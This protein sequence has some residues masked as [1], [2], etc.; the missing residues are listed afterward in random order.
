MNAEF[1]ALM[2][3]M[4]IKHYTTEDPVVKSSI[5]ER[6]IRTI[7]D[8]MFRYFTHTGKWVWYN[9]L[10]KLEKS[11]NNSYHRSIKMRPIDVNRR[12]TTEV[13]KNLYGEE[14]KQAKNFKLPIGTKVRITRAENPFTKG[15]SR[16]F[17]DE[18]FTITKHIPGTT[19][20][21]GIQDQKGVDLIGSFYPQVW[22]S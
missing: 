16:K 18:I 7:K 11:Y 8:R 3:E 1:Q 10:G 19:V 21:Y 15:Y 5:V 13:F 9:V 12:N 20:R 17:T 22:L 4:A 14:Y 6:F 2:K